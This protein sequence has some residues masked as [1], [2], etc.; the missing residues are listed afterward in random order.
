MR[1]NLRILTYL[2]IFNF[3]IVILAITYWQ[4]IKRDAIYA[5]P[6]NKRLYALEAK[7]LR[8]QILDRE[9][10]VLAYSKKVDHGYIRVFPEG[11]VT[12][13]LVGYN[14]A[15][16]GKAGLEYSA[17]TYLLGLN[18][19]ETV[20]PFLPDLQK[21]RYGYD[22]LTT[23]D[24]PLQELAYRLL[25]E[26]KGAVVVLRPQTGE[27]LALVSK[28]SY[29]PNEV[30]K[31]W[32]FL[33]KE[34][35]GSPLL[36]RATQGM[37]PPGST[38]KVVT[39]AG[40]LK[41][42][43]ANWTRIFNAPGYV[44]IRGN[45]IDDSHVV[46]KVGFVEALQR[47]SNYVFATL[48]L[49]MGAQNFYDIMQV[50]GLTDKTPFELP[51][52]KGIVAGP[53]E[54]V[55]EALAETAIG[56][57]RTLVTPLHMALVAATVA[58]GG[59]KV[60]PYLIK[61]VRRHDGTVISQTTPAQA[62][63]VVSPDINRKLVEAMRAVVEKGTGRPAR[64][65]GISVAGKTGSAENPHGET[66]AWFIGFAPVENPQVAVA[67]IVE[68]GGTGGQVAGPIARELFRAAIIDKR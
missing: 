37:Y 22:V 42:N 49:E 35:N 24:L 36:N 48:G 14:S 56:Q 31:N 40:A 25:G 9:G 62:Q 15:K 60:A 21:E 20:F 41:F 2:L 47:S 34:G 18:S 8:G 32:L 53:G 26:R 7:T 12:A 67:I 28:P 30:E 19:E 3:L 38:L 65:P 27:V 17:N 11:E 43:P 52:K 63:R 57:G 61:E 51:T 46:G 59:N 4:V 45:R 39:G 64:L 66:H 13:H 58:N 10:K 50:F 29:N 44:I 16:Y 6:R 23:I 68:N 1:R 5:H 55:P 54:L 33:Q